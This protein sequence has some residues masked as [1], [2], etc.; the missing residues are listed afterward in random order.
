MWGGGNCVIFES[1]LDKTWADQ[2]EEMP[3]SRTR[4]EH[5]APFSFGKI[6]LI[7]QP[8]MFLKSPWSYRFSTLWVLYRP[9][10][11]LSPWL[12][13]HPWEATKPCSHQPTEQLREGERASFLMFFS[14]FHTIKVVCNILCPVFITCI[15]QQI[16]PQCKTPMFLILWIRAHHT[17]PSL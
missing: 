1:Y 15:Q 8:V 17:P 11:V 14:Y 3:Q 7:K 16:Q 2:T 9:C 12:P 5:L 4:T 10:P 13:K 6:F